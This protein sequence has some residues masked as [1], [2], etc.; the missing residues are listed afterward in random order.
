MVGATEPRA[1]GW[2]LDVGLALCGDHY[3]D[4]DRPLP[5]QVWVLVLD[6]VQDLGGDSYVVLCEHLLERLLLL[7]ATLSILERHE[8][9][10]ADGGG[11][12]EVVQL[13]DV[14][15]D[16]DLRNEGLRVLCGA[17]CDTGILCRSVF[18]YG[19]T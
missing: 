2:G 16:L 1:V 15:L 12:N 11:G 18:Q 8:A 5:G 6:G 3:G 10:V 9:P 7:A 13:S 14:E 4:T 19:Q 17:R